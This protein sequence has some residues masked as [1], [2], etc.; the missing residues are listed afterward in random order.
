MR[1]HLILT[2]ILI[3]AFAV[4]GQEKP[5]IENR[6]DQLKTS[7]QLT[8]QQS[9]QVE[10]ILKKTAE[11]A[12]KLRDRNYKQ[13]QEMHAAHLRLIDR[14]ESQISSLLNEEQKKRFDFYRKNQPGTKR[15]MRLQKHLNLDADQTYKIGQILRAARD[16]TLALKEKE[17]SREA[18]YKAM[19]S[20]RE[21]TDKKIVSLLDEKQKAEYTK[22]KQRLWTR[23]DGTM[24]HKCGVSRHKGNRKQPYKQDF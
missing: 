1:I 6:L 16:K 11:E 13:Q 9:K 5:R 14:A 20:I 15:L 8:D 17:Q 7:L 22:M 23:S 10:Q 2:A 18:R 19:L 4:Y 24:R 3:A 12:E 21:E